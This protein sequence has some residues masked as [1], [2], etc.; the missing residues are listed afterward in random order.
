MSEPEKYEVLE[1]IGLYS[2]ISVK[3]FVTDTLEVMDRSG[4]FTK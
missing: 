3:G 1:K 2:Y 4:S